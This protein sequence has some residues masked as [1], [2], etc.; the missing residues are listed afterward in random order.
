MSIQFLKISRPGHA[1][2]RGGAVDDDRGRPLR[3]LAGEDDR[4]HPAHRG[5]VDVRLRDLERVHQAGQVV[6]PDLHVVVLDGPVGLAV[7]AH[8]VVDDLEVLRQLGRAGAK[9]KW[10]KP[11][12][13]ICTTG[14]PSPVIWYQRSTPLTATLPSISATV[15]MRQRAPPGARRPRRPRRR[16]RT[17][18]RCR[19]GSPR[20]RPGCGRRPPRAGRR[21]VAVLDRVDGGR[22]HAPRGRGAGDDHAV[23]AVRGEQAR[24]R[25][26]RR[27]RRRRACSAP[28]RPAAARCAGRSRPSGSPPRA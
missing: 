2:L 11:A 14:S 13:W 9:L 4:D 3:V 21:P 26:C 12:P 7:A 16:R 23:A 6:R 18:C 17:S 28:A 24:E 22:A 15:T 20:A 19:R 5:A 25:A 1:E 27:T 8:V 10:P